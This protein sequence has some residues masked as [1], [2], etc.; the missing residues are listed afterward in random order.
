MRGI[1]LLGS[2]PVIQGAT[3]PLDLAPADYVSKAVVCIFPVAP[4]NLT[5]QYITTNPEAIGKTFH[6]VNDTGSI[7]INDLVEFIT[8]FGYKIEKL[9]VTSWTKILEHKIAHHDTPSKYVVSRVRSNLCREENPLLPLL[10]F[11]KGGMIG[12]QPNWRAP[13]TRSFLEKAR[14]FPTPK[15]L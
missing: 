15:P 7:T 13:H 12:G 10:E 3:N 6:M 11:V 5:N 1:V 9:D 14:I 4:N 2:G 8:S